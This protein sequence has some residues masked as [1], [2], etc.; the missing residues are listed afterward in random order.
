ML[1]ENEAVRVFLCFRDF[2]GKYVM[3]CHNVIH[4]DHGMMLRW[5]IEDDTPPEP[6]AGCSLS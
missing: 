5:D 3:H 1:G 4:E 2:T 6:P